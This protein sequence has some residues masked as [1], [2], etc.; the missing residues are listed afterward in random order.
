MSL[1]KGTRG[2]MPLTTESSAE[3]EHERAQFLFDLM[4]EVG[5][6]AMSTEELEE[7]TYLMSKSL[8]GKGNMPLTEVATLYPKEFRDAV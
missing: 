7:W 2:V 3:D 4:R 5:L 6:T 8:E 1:R